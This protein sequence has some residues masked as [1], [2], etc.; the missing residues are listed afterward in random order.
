MRRVPPTR[1]S[2]KIRRV[3]P[4]HWSRKNA[5]CATDRLLNLK[6]TRRSLI[7]SSKSSRLFATGGTTSVASDTYM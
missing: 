5:R 6:L 2:R 3:P 7:A 4:T 1:W